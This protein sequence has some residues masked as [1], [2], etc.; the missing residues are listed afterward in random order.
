MTN[1]ILA[2]FLSPHYGAIPP[3]E[4]LQDMELAGI[5][6]IVISPLTLILIFQKFSD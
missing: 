1:F 3:V 4:A 6:H 5:E 2:V